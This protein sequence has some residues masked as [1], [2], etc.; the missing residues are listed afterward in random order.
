[1]LL[2]HEL[3]EVRDRVLLLC[4]KLETARDRELPTYRPIIEE[5][6]SA[7][8]KA[9]DDARIPEHY[10]VAVVGRFK[11]GKSSFVNKLAQEQLAGVETSPET[12]AISVFRFAEQARAEV[13][14]V[15]KETWDNLRTTYEEN[16]DDNEAKRYAGF[17]KFNHRPPSRDRDGRERVRETVDVA[18]LEAQWVKPGGHVHTLAAGDWKSREAK[19][20]KRGQARKKK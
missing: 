11:V 1:M 20:G 19:K 4:Q 7:L 3:H 17:A 10:R 5:E 18:H 13:E 6:I 15:S 12:A 8:R 9:L 2:V 14:L 16:P